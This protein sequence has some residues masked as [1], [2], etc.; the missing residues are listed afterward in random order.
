MQPFQLNP[1][2]EFAGFVNPLIAFAQSK[3]VD[4][5]YGEQVKAYPSDPLV[6]K[7]LPNTTILWEDTTETQGLIYEYYQSLSTST[8]QNPHYPKDLQQ[9][10][11]ANAG[12]DLFWNWS[13]RK[14]GLVPG[15]IPFFKTIRTAVYKTGEG[16]EVIVPPELIKELGPS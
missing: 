3:G 6:G 14:M 9:I 12:P 8:P 5:N 16:V 11:E 15:S 13:Y 2:L 10:L 7:T 4:Y 1:E